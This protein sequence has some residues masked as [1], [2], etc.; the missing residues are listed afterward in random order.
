M[1]LANEYK[2]KISSIISNVESHTKAEVVCVLIDNSL[3]IKK[4]SRNSLILLMI[5]FSILLTF[6][7]SNSSIL[8]SFQILFFIAVELFCQ[9][10]EKILSFVFSKKKKIEKA[11]KKAEKIFN[12]FEF[13][14]CDNV[15][16]FFVSFDEKSS[17]IIAGKNISR[18]IDDKIWQNIILNFSKN[19]QKFIFDEA[20]KIAINEISEEILKI[21]ALKS[22]DNIDEIKDKIVE[23]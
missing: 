2:N 10:S 16:M 4:I 14:N 11:N 1:K 19:M 21:D 15:V 5:F 6:F 23:L 3:E 7:V 12:E 18:F 20:M 9:F 17:R 13:D 22:S 8:L